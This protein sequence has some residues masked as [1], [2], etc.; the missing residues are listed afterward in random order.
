[1]RVGKVSSDKNKFDNQKAYETYVNEE[2]SDG[3]KTYFCYDTSKKTVVRNEA[4]INEYLSK[5]G[6]FIILSGKADLPKE[7]FLSAYRNK[8]KVEKIFDNTKNELNTNRLHS[9]S[10]TTTEG[11]LFVKF[12]AT[13]LYQQIT[14]VMKENDMFK[15]YSVTELL[16]ELSKI[17]MI[18]LPELDDFTSECAKRQNDIFEKFKIKI[19]T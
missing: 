4:K 10:K 11:R 15:K 2:I 12:I 1:M 8:D 7:E 14:K 9:H 19:P 3:Y 16:K 5:L 13:I 18:S 17:K 6:F